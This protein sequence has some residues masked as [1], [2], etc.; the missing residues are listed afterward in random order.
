MKRKYFIY[1]LLIIAIVTF[2]SACREKDT[3]NNDSVKTPE[4]TS[5]NDS[6][7][8]PEKTPV[9][10]SNKEII[11]IL[12][13]TSELL[14][15]EK[16]QE[17][18]TMITTTNQKVVSNQYTQDIKT[19]V[20]IDCSC[21]K[22]NDSNIFKVVMNV[23]S[24]GTKSSETSYYS[25][26]Y[27]YSDTLNGKFAFACTEDE[28][29]AFYD[30]DE[31]P[32]DEDLL[33][34]EEQ[35]KDIK[36]E[37]KNGENVYTVDIDKSFMKAI[38]GEEEMPE[39]TTLSSIV[40]LD[41]NN[42]VKSMAFDVFTKEK[43]EEDGVKYDVEIKMNIFQAVKDFEDFTLPDLSGYEKGTIDEEGNFIPS[44]II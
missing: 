40:T 1:L 2:L 4:H 11:D 26:G 8:T 32:E 19:V 39:D 6:V 9:K 24:M 43:S 5:N 33:L 30:L 34:K 38:M 18:Y 35:V 28:F 27:C 16:D 25:D 31:E 41:S 21:K 14:G 29:L 44:E 7:K 13:G 3:S 42:M 37:N 17:S 22:V 15:E 23:D 36:Y 10:L 12:N 20:T